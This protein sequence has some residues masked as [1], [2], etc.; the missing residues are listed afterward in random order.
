MLIWMFNLLAL[1][2]PEVWI[3]LRP[4]NRLSHYADPRRFNYDGAINSPSLPIYVERWP[5]SDIPAYPRITFRGLCRLEPKL[6]MHCCQ[7]AY[8]RVRYDE[9]ATGKLCPIGPS[10]WG[11]KQGE[12]KRIPVIGIAL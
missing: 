12:L 6:A 10:S 3:R 5:L 9:M 2:K 11:V 1:Y 7:R 8:A 4:R